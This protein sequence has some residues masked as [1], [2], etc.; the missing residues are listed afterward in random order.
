MDLFINLNLCKL[1]IYLHAFIVEAT[2][3]NSEKKFFN[4]FKLQ[5]KIY[6]YGQISIICLLI[7]K[8]IVDVEHELSSVPRRMQYSFPSSNRLSSV[9]LISDSF[10]QILVKVVQ[11]SPEQ[12]D[13]SI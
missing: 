11:F 13:T 5:Q 10:A 7:M 12:A 6:T 3:I 9:I 8:W 4:L 1:E 2:F